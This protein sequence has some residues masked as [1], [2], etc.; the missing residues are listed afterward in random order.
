MRI[1]SLACS[2]TEIVAAL[3]CAHL[4]VGVDS[5]SDFPPEVVNALPRMG[6]DLEIDVSRVVALEPDLVLASLTV[7]GH[8]TV[9]EGVEAAGLPVLTL[10]P[11]SIADVY[12]NIREVAR[13]LGVED[14]GAEVVAELEAALAPPD[15]PSGGSPDPG[16]PP[17]RILIQWW[18]KPVIAP[19]ARS[20]AHEVIVAAGG[21]NPLAHEDRPSRPLTDEEVAALAP[22]AVVV[23]WCGVEPEKYRPEVVARN[24]AFREIPAV[25]HG[26]IHCVPEAFL[27]RPGPRLAEGVRALRQV[28]RSVRAGRRELPTS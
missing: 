26:Q 17:P 24:P 12:A 10:D 6:P 4:L 1:V 16:D 2:N 9:V 14:R 19:G 27:G 11:T 28:V 22:D 25:T 18:P 23:A 21:A 13:R 3:G 7:P 8:E 5:H 15:A 20:W